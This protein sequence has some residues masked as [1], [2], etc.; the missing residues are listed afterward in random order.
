MKA[1]E[2]CYSVSVCPIQTIDHL[3]MKTA[4][5]MRSLLTAQMVA[6][7]PIAQLIHADNLP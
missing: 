7:M 4:T 3:K 6:E 2:T 5:P 1:N